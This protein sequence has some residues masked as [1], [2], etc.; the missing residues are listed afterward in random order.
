MGVHAYVCEVGCSVVSLVQCWTPWYACAPHGRVSV[1]CCSQE[2]RLL[3][4]LSGHPYISGVNCT[5]DQDNDIYLEMPY[6]EGGTLT[7]WM[8]AL[9]EPPRRTQEVLRSVLRQLMLAL[10]HVHALKVVHCDVKPDNIFMESCD[11]PVIRL[12]DFDVSIDNKTRSM[13]MASQLLTRPDHGLTPL[14]AAPELFLNPPALASGAS[15][16]Y[17][18]GLICVKLFY[19]EVTWQA[20]QSPAVPRPRAE[21]SKEAHQLYTL[22]CA[23]LDR[24]PAKRPGLADILA[25]PFFSETS[26]VL[27]Q[28]LHSH[29]EASRVQRGRARTCCIC[30]DDELFLSQGVE[31]GTDDAKHGARHFLCNECFDAHVHTQATQEVGCLEARRGEITCPCATPQLQCQAGPYPIETVAKHAGPVAVRA[32][33]HSL[34]QLQER[35]LAAD[36]D[37]KTKEAIKAELARLAKLSELERKVETAR[38][39]V[40]DDLLT[41]KCPHAGCQQA[42]VDF[43]NC[44]A[45]T[46]SR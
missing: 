34:T 28:E 13:S 35:R 43:S 9:S 25:H 23:W 37:A 20:G 40:E 31:C 8:Q 2:T 21:D 22:L 36:M 42:F 26:L 16:V 33:L 30:L 7:T 11:P 12:G 14:F 32:F 27:A 18:V 19:P 38:K 15:D 10:Q 45:L 24:D 6:Y 44:F 41:L 1:L 3:Q 4:R 39:H 17:S 29:L 46:C 5:F